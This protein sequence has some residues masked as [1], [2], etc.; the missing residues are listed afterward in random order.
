M[1]VLLAS[2]NPK[3]AAELLH[4]LKPFGFGVLQ[5]ADVGGLPEVIEDQ[6]TFEGNAAK[7]AISAARASGQISLAD[8]SGLCVDAL[9][10]APGVHSARYSGVHGD[11]AA[12]NAKLLAALEGLPES[13]RGAHFVCTLCVA[14]PEGKI[15]FQTR[16]EVH[17]RIRSDARGEF[18]FGYDP[19]FDL[20][21]PESPFH[22]RVMAE[23]QPHEKAQVSHRGRALQNLA[24]LLSQ[25]QPNPL[26]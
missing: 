9:D 8:D 14:N 26:S 18:G 7:K 20:D 21:E 23:L 22:G 15:L 19:L 17:G 10:G 11:D 12:N 6:P 16:G 25:A 4:M 1:N 24:A 3:K 5:P 13:A 2:G